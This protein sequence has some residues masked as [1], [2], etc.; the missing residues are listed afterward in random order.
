MTSFRFIDK[1]LKL[2]DFTT[3]KRV[4]II[5]LFFTEK[6]WQKHI[7]FFSDEKAPKSHSWGLASP[8]KNPPGNG[9]HLRMIY[10]LSICTLFSVEKYRPVLSETNYG[11]AS[12]SLQGCFWHR[13]C[14]ILNKS[15]HLVWGGS[16]GLLTRTHS[17][18][19][20]FNCL[21]VFSSKFMFKQI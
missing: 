18:N 21:F 15:L 5:Q 12:F 16:A 2:Y 20:D 7:R 6:S 11:T 13:W 8:P 1:P 4:I 10:I 17:S 9:R 14:F 3:A 19:L